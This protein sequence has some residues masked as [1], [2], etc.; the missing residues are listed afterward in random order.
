MKWVIYAVLSNRFYQ[1]PMIFLYYDTWDVPGG[2]STY[3]HALAVH[4][5]AEE[6][7]FQIVISEKAPS[8]IA[9]E[10]EMKGIKIYRQP[11]LPGDRWLL[12]K[13]V[14]LAWL[15]RQLQPGDW[16]FCVCHPEPS[17]Y[18]KLVR[19]VHRRQAKIA[20]RWLV[21][22]EFWPLSPEIVGSYAEDYRQAI[23]ETDSV[24]STS[25]CSIYQFKQVYGYTGQVDVVPYHNL[26]FF[27]EAVSLPSSPPWKIGFMGRLDIQQK[28]LDTVLRAMAQVRQ[29]RQDVELHLY[30]GGQDRS[31]LEELALELG[32]Q[33]F[34]YFHGAY[35]H[36][37]DLKTIIGDCQFFIYPSR[38]EGLPLSLLELL[39]AGRFCVASDVGGMS[40]LYGGYPDIGLM[41]DSSSEEAI[42]QG[43]LQ[44]VEKLENGLVDGDKIRAR[45]FDGFDIVTAHRAWMS[46]MRPEAASTQ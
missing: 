41:M 5:H 16:V 9:D 21:T 2:I 7:P 44:A 19:L 11:K 18:L 37:R 26:P 34:V 17:L 33:D 45:Y 32:I 25:K 20:V 22:P 27:T 36:R 1:H 30:G 39:Q 42:Y 46:V 10:L 15:E 43:F 28:N 31:A 8:P 38:W 24:I 35:D 6:I 3:I 40:D 14:M 13:H 12:R 29:V 4:L 23:F